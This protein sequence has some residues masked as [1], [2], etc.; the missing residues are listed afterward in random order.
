MIRV[1]KSSTKRLIRRGFELFGFEKYSHPSLHGLDQKIMKYLPEHS[2]VFIEVGANN[3][4]SQSNTYYL[5]RFKKWK[6][7]LIEPIPDLYKECLKERKNSKVFN[8]ALVADDY[9]KDYVEIHSASLMSVIAG[10]V[11]NEIEYLQK[12]KKTEKKLTPKVIIVLARTLTSILE[13]CNVEKIN[14][15]SLDVEGYELQV[16]K[17]LDFNKFSPDY[18]LIEVNDF[19]N[20]EIIKAYM[21]EKNYTLVTQ[22]SSE[23]IL[24]RSNRIV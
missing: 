23:D 20:P 15:F 2:G 24:F 8:C 6:G 13:E 11:E 12:A 22:L 1:L 3:G 21:A 16:L 17:G 14:F 19:N 7:I 10:S 9:E 4:Y 5:E 18:I